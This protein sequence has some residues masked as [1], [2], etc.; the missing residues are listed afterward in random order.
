MGTAMQDLISAL[1]ALALFCLGYAGLLSFLDFNVHE[2]L[3]DRI[4]AQ[5]GHQS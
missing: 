1:Y 5:H 2:W 4:K 3:A